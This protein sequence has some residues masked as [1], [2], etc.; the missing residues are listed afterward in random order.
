MSNSEQR[1]AIFS[2]KTYF[3]SLRLMF[4]FYACANNLRGSSSIKAVQVRLVNVVVLRPRLN[5][6]QIVQVGTIERI[7]AIG[8][9]NTRPR[10]ARTL[11][12]GA[13]LVEGARPA[14]LALLTQAT[15]AR[16]E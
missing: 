1:L 2:V 13:D 4:E 10:L 7:I 11:C 6:R 16:R 12:G 5:C 3:G 14:I 8:R 15:Y 9:C